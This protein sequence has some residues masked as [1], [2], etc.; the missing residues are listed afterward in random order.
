MTPQLIETPAALASLCDA[1]AGRPLL[2]VDT[3]FARERTYFPQVGLIQI[4]SDRHVACI[5]PLALEVG[6]HLT[7]LLSDPG[8]TKVF[9]ACPQDLEVLELTLGK[10]ACPVFDTQ[11]AHALMH[12][13]HQV[14][15]ARLVNQE[16]NVDLAKSQTRTDWLRR[17]LTQA[18]LAYAADDV[19]YLLPLRLRQLA[20]LETLGRLS[21]INEEN[22]RVCARPASTE[23]D[24]SQSW[25]RVRG[26]ERLRGQE[27]AVLQAAAGW[28]EQQAIVRDRPRRRILTDATLIQ[29]ALVKPRNITALRKIDRIEKCL[30]LPE[31]DA[32]V[33]SL[34]TAYEKGGSEWPNLR[35]QQLT[36][37][38]SAAL[39]K[40]LELLR[41]KAAEL[42][43]AAGV[44]C[45]RKEAE[46]LVLGKRDLTVLSGWRR[47]CVGSELLQSLPAED[48]T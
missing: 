40:I 24:V 18:Q 2:A 39:T 1:M 47:Q 12:T 14:S 43:I 48:R 42:G 10:A 30:R 23:A 21:W 34:C 11:L 35:R 45:N 8:I 4:A 32:L 13:E 28:R 22:A 26:K 3:E 17:P 5:D 7:E 46:K 31:L 9:H 33:E 15:Y 38:Q 25:L 44:L 6:P 16:L 36:R 41:S 37:T 29:I 19:R 27:L 20:E